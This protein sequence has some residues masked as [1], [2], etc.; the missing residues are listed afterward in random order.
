MTWYSY[1]NLSYLRNIEFRVRF[2]ITKVKIFSEINER[3]A[4]GTKLFITLF[5]EIGNDARTT[6]FAGCMSFGA[7]KIIQEKSIFKVRVKV[8]LSI[9]AYS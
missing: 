9:L 1:D 7:R 3:P 2:S 6:E 4:S 8:E 5:L